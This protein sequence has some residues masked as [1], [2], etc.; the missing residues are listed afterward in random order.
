MK[1]IEEIEKW[2]SNYINEEFGWGE[3]LKNTVS[4]YRE[5]LESKK[6]ISFVEMEEEKETYQSWVK[7]MEDYKAWYKYWKKEKALLFIF[8]TEVKKSINFSKT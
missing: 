5:V 2:A 8:L 3:K 4:L 1:T 7:G 6:V